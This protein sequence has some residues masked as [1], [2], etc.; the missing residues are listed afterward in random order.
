MQNPSNGDYW[1][2]PTNNT[3]SVKRS[4]SWTT[5]TTSVSQLYVSPTPDSINDAQYKAYGNIIYRGNG[6]NGLI[7]L[8]N[9]DELTNTLVNLA[10][11]L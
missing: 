3:L 4:E 7:P 10:E 6:V 1:Y 2:N 11:T 8:S 5:V 9:D